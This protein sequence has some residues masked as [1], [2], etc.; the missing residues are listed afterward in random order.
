[1]GRLAACGSNASPNG[2]L[3]E[4]LV[5]VTLGVGLP[6]VAIWLAVN[7]TTVGLVPSRFDTQRLPL[8]SKA[9]PAGPFSEPAFALRVTTGVGLPVVVSWLGENATTVFCP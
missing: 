3:R 8:A 6:L 9:N 4:L 7:P 5:T 2:S 1:M